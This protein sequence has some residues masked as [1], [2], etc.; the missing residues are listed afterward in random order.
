[1]LRLYA[2]TASFYVRGLSIH[3]FGICGGWVGPLRLPLPYHGRLHL[4]TDAPH[5]QWYIVLLV[6]GFL[7]EF[8]HSMYV[9][10]WFL[11]P[12]K[13]KKTSWNPQLKLIVVVWVWC[14]LPST[15]RAW[16]PVGGAISV[17]FRD[18][19][20]EAILCSRCLCFTLFLSSLCFMFPLSWCSLTMG[21]E[22]TKPK[23]TD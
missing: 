18:V 6:P 11:K 16:F 5:S 1:M 7:L 22:S 8:L 2:N 10:L 17:R 23:T 12:K 14:A 20:L 13:K 9:L 15:K 19:S 21:P 4:I 3:E